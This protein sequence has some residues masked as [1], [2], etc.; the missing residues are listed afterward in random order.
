MRLVWAACISIAS[1][2]DLAKKRPTPFCH[3]RDHVDLTM[4]VV[5][6]YATAKHGSFLFAG[7]GFLGLIGLFIHRYLTIISSGLYISAK[8]VN[9]KEKAKCEDRNFV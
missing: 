3:H 2:D 8:V 5:M 4:S 6:P 1:S 7:E 9:K